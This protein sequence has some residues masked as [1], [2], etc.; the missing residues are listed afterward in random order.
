MLLFLEEMQHFVT[1][2]VAEAKMEVLGTC[3]T[4]LNADKVSIFLSKIKHYCEA[5]SIFRHVRECLGW[6]CL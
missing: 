3:V 6:S 1:A 2:E 4:S 5:R